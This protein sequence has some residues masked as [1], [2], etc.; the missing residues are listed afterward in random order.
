MPIAVMMESRENTMSMTMIW[1]M[2]QKNALARRRAIVLSV[3][4][5]HL[6]VNFVGRLGDQ[7]QSAADQDDVAPGKADA[8]YREDVLRQP[9]QPHQQA[10]QQNSKHQ[11]QRQADLPRALR[12]PFGYPRD[13]DR[14]E[15]DVVDTENDFQ[16]RQRQQ[17]GPGFGAGP[18]FDHA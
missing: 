2:T 3:A 9:D 17:G 4:G 7:E 14:Q 6:A 15:D 18:Q 1:T 10:E 8:L 11:R 13:D 5:F 12:L 16:R